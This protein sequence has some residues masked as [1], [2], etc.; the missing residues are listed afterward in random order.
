[1]LIG[2]F[3]NKIDQNVKK[4]IPGGLPPDPVVHR[5]NLQKTSKIGTAKLDRGALDTAHQEG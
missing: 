4:I 3:D 5:K 2:H 1:M